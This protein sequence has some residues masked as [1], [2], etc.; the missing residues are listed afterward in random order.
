MTDKERFIHI[1]EENCSDRF[2]VKKFIDYLI[3]DTDFFNCPAS[4][5]YHLNE[6]GGLLKHSLNVYDSLMILRELY[7]EEISLDSIA[8]VGLLHDV[9]KINFYKLES[10]NVKSSFGWTT[11]MCYVIDDTF[12]VGHGEKSVIILQNFM[13]LTT[14]E[15]LAIRWHMSGFDYAVKGSDPSYS[16]AIQMSKLLSLLEIADNIAS[17]LLE[18]KY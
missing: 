7:A 9:C 12:P 13:R 16:K 11:Q 8:I 14:D 17:R 5:K 2:D 15:I 18:V 3:N 1:L 10:K 4:T 6:R